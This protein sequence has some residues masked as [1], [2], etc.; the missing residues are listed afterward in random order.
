MLCNKTKARE[1]K[2]IMLNNVLNGTYRTMLGYLNFNLLSYCPIDYSRIRI[3][4][5]YKSYY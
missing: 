2:Q 5:E 4:I 3:T 1:H